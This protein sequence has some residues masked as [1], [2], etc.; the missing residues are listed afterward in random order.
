VVLAGLVGSAAGDRQSLRAQYFD[1][2]QLNDGNTNVFVFPDAC[3]ATPEKTLWCNCVRSAFTQPVKGSPSGFRQAILW[4]AEH[5]GNGF[6]RSEVPFG[7][8]DVSRVQVGN[9]LGEAGANEL[10]PEVLPLVGGEFFTVRAEVRVTEV[11]AGELDFRIVI[12]E[13]TRAVTVAI[14]YDPTDETHSFGHLFDGRLTSHGP[15]RGFTVEYRYATENFQADPRRFPGLQPGEVAGPVFNIPFRLEYFTTESGVFTLPQD[16]AVSVLTTLRGFTPGTLPSIP[17]LGVDDPCEGE[18]LDTPCKVIEEIL[19]LRDSAS[20]NSPPVAVIQ[21]L[22][23]GS[24]TL[25]SAPIELQTFCGSARIMFRGRNSEDGDGGFQPLSF[26]WSV[27]G[28]PEGGAVLPDAT[29]RF[30]DAEITFMRAGSYTVSLRVEDG[31]GPQS[32]GEA[33]VDVTVRS[34]FDVN[35][36][37]VARIAT[38]PSPARVTLQNGIAS[39]LLDGSGSSNGILGEDDCRQAL[40]YRWRQVKTNAAMDATILG[41]Q[42]AATQVLFQAQGLYVFELEV[43]DGAAEDQTDTEEV[44]VTVLGDSTEPRFRR[45]DST[46][47]GQLNITDP[48]RLLNFLF[49]GNVEAPSCRDAADSDDDGVLSIT[50]AIQVLRF[51]FLGGLAPAPPGPTTCGQDPTPD[52]LPRCSSLVCG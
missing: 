20:E 45:G 23:S 7:T 25:L 42:D 33:S 12:I 4:I 39:V 28:D 14:N 51:L 15:G 17:P 40:R 38:L 29:R 8:L 13:A 3:L 34:D 32:F 22:D 31:A 2:I 43:D 11:R 24:L 19:D 1:C 41:P 37:P 35:V 10:V 30:M 47:D 52:S 50:D 44:E 26:T 46:D 48:I 49:L 36:P 9:V 21:P 16:P 27:S 18:D 6:H 5:P